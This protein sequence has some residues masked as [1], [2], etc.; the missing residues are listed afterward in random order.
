MNT[1]TEFLREKKLKKTPLRVAILEI[2]LEKKEPIT[3]ADLGKFL[4]KKKFFPNQTSLYRQIE[5]LTEK[6][7]LQSLIL[8]NSIA[9]Y[10][11]QNH[12]HHH[13]VCN[14]CEKIECVDDETLENEI[15]TLETKLKKK[16]MHISSHQFSFHGECQSCTFSEA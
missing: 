6:E 15:H 9:H 1:I 8:K 7:I 10:E 11:L 16:G 4:E 14:T 5:S 12:H 13:F 3:I 2:F